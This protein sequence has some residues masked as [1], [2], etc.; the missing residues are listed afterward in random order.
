[1]KQPTIPP[2]FLIDFTGIVVAVIAV[3]ILFD[4]R[5]SIG[6]RVGV[7]LV[8]LIWG[9]LFNV[10]ALGWSIVFVN[11]SLFPEISYFWVDPHDLLMAIGMLFFL[12]AARKFILLKHPA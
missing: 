1:M 4:L 5:N 7:A 9:I 8:P 11:L 3:I 12:I 6:G 2:E 10:A